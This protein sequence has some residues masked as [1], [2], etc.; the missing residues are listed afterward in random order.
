MKCV[1]ALQNR[2]LLGR[3]SISS[4]MEAPVVVKPE[5][6]SNQAF[7]RVKG[8]PHSAYG[9]MPNTKDSSHDRKIII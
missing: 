8:P 3:A 7:A 9:S 5:T 1:E 4:S 2:R 6:L